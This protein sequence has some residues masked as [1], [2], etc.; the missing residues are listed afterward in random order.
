[1]SVMDKNRKMPYYS[2]FSSSIVMIHKFS[3][4]FSSMHKIYIALLK[5]TKMTDFQL[6]KM[7]ESQTIEQY[8]LYKS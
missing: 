2:L 4:F 5:T 8:R 1:M 6:S 3:S 7:L